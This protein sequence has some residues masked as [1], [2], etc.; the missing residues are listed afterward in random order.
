MRQCVVVV[1]PLP[2]PVRCTNKKVARAPTG[3]AMLNTNRC[4]RAARLDSPCL[5]R[6]DVSP[7]DAGA[8]WTMI[9][10]KMI[11]LSPASELDAPNAMPSA[12]AWM[13]RP[14]VV[15]KLW[16]RRGEVAAS[17]SPPSREGDEV[18]R[19][20]ELKLSREMWYGG[21]CCLGVEANSGS[22]SMRYIKINPL[23]RATPIH[24]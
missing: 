23:T 5:S 21:R 13:T 1:S 19:R 4:V 2:D 20:P 3:A 10:R 11:K 22:L 6:T 16:L 7:K 17:S 15:A 9:A 8:L 18:R 14:V 24:A 12:A